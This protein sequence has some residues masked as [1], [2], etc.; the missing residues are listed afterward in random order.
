MSFGDPQPEFVF[1]RVLLLESVEGDFVG[2]VKPGEDVLGGADGGIGVSVGSSLDGVEFGFIVWGDVFG[3]ESFLEVGHLH[4]VVLFFSWI[5]SDAP[6]VIENTYDDGFGRGGR[7]GGGGGRCI[8]RLF[9]EELL[10]LLLDEL[11]D[12]VFV[13]PVSGVVFHG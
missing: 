4:D 2:V 8:I 12:L 11:D 3:V 9:F 7:G 5:M 13:V 6:F 1:H 10:L